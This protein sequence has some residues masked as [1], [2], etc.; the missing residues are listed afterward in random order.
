[1][2]TDGAINHDHSY[3]GNGCTN[4]YDS[5]KPDEGYGG[6][7]KSC[8]T[9]VIQTTDEENQ[10]IGVYYNYTASTSGT[11]GTTAT[12]PG[13]I[14]PDTFCPL[15]WQLP[16]GGSGGDYYVQS[17]S[18]NYLFQT[19]DIVGKYNKITAYPT[20][21]ISAGYYVLA[22][23]RLFET[24]FIGEHWSITNASANA[25][26]RLYNST[27]A[28]PDNKSIAFTVRCVSVLAS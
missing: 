23:G 7:S 8:S 24:T 11:G 13:A 6:S 4:R 9:R 3:Y 28:H 12:E 1:M 22:L 16:N 26:Y 19:Y 25:A 2:I 5:S 10:E 27:T 17:K 18:W 14:I 15:G 20:S 21:F